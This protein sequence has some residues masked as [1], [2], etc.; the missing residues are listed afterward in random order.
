MARVAVPHLAIPF[1]FGG[2]GHAVVVEQDSDADVEACVEAIVRTPLGARA[3]LPTFGVDDGAFSG[4]LNSDEVIEAISIHEPRAEPDV[5][6]AFLDAETVEST[7][8][9]LLPPD[10]TQEGR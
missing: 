3:E 4:G 1:R 6:S 9:P 8:T 2:N 7:V 10:R 5:V